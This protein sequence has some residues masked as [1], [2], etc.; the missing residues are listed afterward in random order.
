MKTI[1]E[2]RYAKEIS[3]KVVICRAIWEYSANNAPKLHIKG[4]NPF[5]LY[6]NGV[7][8]T[9]SIFHRWME[10][11]GWKMCLNVSDIFGKYTIKE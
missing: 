5:P 4:Y 9:K 10:E 6:V 11:N 2:N 3:G 1:I 8:S 7:P